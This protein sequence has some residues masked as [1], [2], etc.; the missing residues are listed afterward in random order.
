M[1]RFGAVGREC[2]GF[3]DHGRPVRAL[4]GA[5]ER[6]AGM[7]R[8]GLGGL[9]G[10]LYHLLGLFHG[11]VPIAGERRDFESGVEHGGQRLGLLGRYLG[12]RVVRQELVV[13]GKVRGRY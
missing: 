13:G 11:N 5:H 10:G 2:I 9:S 1:A 8:H 4:P 3:G 12:R 7:A 6:L